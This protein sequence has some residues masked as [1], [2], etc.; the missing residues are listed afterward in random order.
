LKKPAGFIPCFK[1][2]SMQFLFSMHLSLTHSFCLGLA[3]SHSQAKYFLKVSFVNSNFV[4][5]SSDV[6]V[7]LGSRSA[8]IIRSVLVLGVGLYVALYAFLVLGSSAFIKI[9]IG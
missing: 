8:I 2:L 3:F 6:R 4:L 5:L 9:L 1:L 7:R